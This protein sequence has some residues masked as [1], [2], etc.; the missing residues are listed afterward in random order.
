ML[1]VDHRKKID[2]RATE[3]S[4]LAKI[5]SN[6]SPA[7]LGISRREF[8]RLAG[9]GAAGLAIT[10]TGAIS[11]AGDTCCAKKSVVLIVKH[12]KILLSGYKADPAVLSTMMN[13][14]MEKLTAVNS[15]EGAWQKLFK[16]SDKV[17]IKY[18]TMSSTNIWTHPELIQVVS[19]SLV[20]KAKIDRKTL[21]PW[22]RD[23]GPE[24]ELAMLSKPFTT[25]THKIE[26]RIIRA[27]SDYGTALINMPILKC[28]SSVGMTI[29]LKNHLGTI[30]NPGDMHQPG[31]WGKGLELNIA[32]VNA[33]PAIK[34][35]TRLI[36]VDA[37]R[38][39]YDGGPGENVRF[40]WDYNGLI[41]GTDPVAV[42]AV[43]LAILEAKRRTEKMENW[44]LT[45]GRNC[46]TYAQTLGLGNSQGSN[47]QVFQ[48]D[49][50]SD[51]PKPVLLPLERVV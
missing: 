47:I 8:L 48:I 22:D 46:L 51:N 20:E 36:V 17:C 11:L 13:V 21:V 28:H 38:P 43:G 26:S 45:P 3:S 49:L 12:P 24:G 29:A 1:G 18:N 44:K 4:E 23:A 27:V 35:K 40:R 5:I 9:I 30:N 6:F 34:D 10:A 25:K 39:L 41:M 50:G 42:D 19:D 14:G 16:P 15:V 2:F 33:H 32:D 37:I 7:Q 31:G